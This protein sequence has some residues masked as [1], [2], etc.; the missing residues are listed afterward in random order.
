[1]AD[2]L[3]RQM[4][5]QDEHIGLRLD[6]VAR[7]W[8]QDFSREQ[9][10]SWIEAGALL[11]QGR[12]ARPSLRVAAGAELRLD[13]EL[14]A[15]TE[16]Q[17]EN[18]PLQLVYEDEDILV[19]DKPAGLVVHPGAGNWQGTLMNALLYHE[20]GLAALPR[21]GIV[22]RLDK[23]TSGLLVVARTAQAQEQLIAQLKD[24][25]LRRI[26]QAFV[27]GVPPAQGEVDAAIGRHP[28]DR[29]RMAIR[30]EGKEART[31]FQRLA[32]YGSFSHIELRLATGRT[33]QIRVH[34]SHLGHPLLGDPVYR[35]PRACLLSAGP[36][37]QAQLV[38]FQ[39]QALHASEL[40]LLHP[41]LGRPLS[42]HSPLPDDLLNLQQA[43]CA[44]AH[45]K[46]ARQA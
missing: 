6:Q 34:M 44:D 10:K 31:H 1:M 40:G 2:T 32:V 39:R 8:L 27:C 19:I 25:S 11:Y 3:Q 22:H 5:V 9:V 38:H 12:Q 14:T 30:P 4:Q 16:A 33:H 15:R 17:A 24:R 26:Y 42:W 35:P 36:A 20:P 7:L 21:A 45:A 41:R 37:L 13:V 46:S 29:L 23:E 28:Q 43:L 18:I